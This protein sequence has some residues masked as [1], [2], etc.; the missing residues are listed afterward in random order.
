MKA[1]LRV[2][3]GYAPGV[4][5]TYAML[6]EGLRRRDRGTDVVV[7][8]V[9]T[10]NRPHTVAA[11]GDLE[12]VPS[13]AL[14]YRGQV[15]HEMDVDAVIARQP[16]VA[17]V[18]ELAHANVPGSKQVKRYQDVLA[19]REYGI[20]VISTVNVQHLASLHETVQLLAGV[21][22]AETLPDW[23]LDAADE[24]EMVDYQPEAL[25]KRLRRGNVQPR[26]QV[27]RALEAFFHL[28]TLTALREL[29]LR[30][31]ALH[32][33]RKL[34]ERGDLEERPVPAPSIE[35]VLVC[36]LRGDEAQSLVRRGVHL[37]DR[38][39]G[40]LIVLQISEPGAGLQ[41]DASVG[42][43]ETVRAL[44]LARALGAEVHTLIADAN[45]AD[46]LVGFATDMGASQIVLAAETHSWL[47]ELFGGW[48]S[49]SGGSIVR[50][51][52]Q[53][54]RDVDVH[55]VRRSQR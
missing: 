4:G 13:R 42:H 30:Q 44:Q 23:V 38:L 52:L 1:W 12:I 37:A 10:Y 32:T 34:Q 47:R 9:Q 29:T 55:I 18:D 45:V 36:V 16:Q 21:T 51:V 11:V 31:K 8:W 40:S 28:D 26:G 54:T 49:R 5:K 53:R 15:L 6:Q 2:Y 46:T 14:D 25:R 20:N 43:Q 48:P 17:L 22:V 35:T 33:Q 24:L 39:R 50:D 41:G 27:E 3:L 7:G 19:L